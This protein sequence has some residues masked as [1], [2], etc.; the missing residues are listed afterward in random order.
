MLRNVVGMLLALAMMVALV[1]CQNNNEFAKYGG[2]PR[3]KTIEN[4]VSLSPNLTEVIGTISRRA[5]AGKTTEC[6]FPINMNDITNV[7]KGTEIDYELVAS[8]EPDLVIYDSDL[9]SE[10]DIEKL[11]ELGIETQGFAPKS[12]GEY[13][14]MMVA[15]AQYIASETRISDDLDDINRALE[16][17]SGAFP[18]GAV[19][20]T[21]LM[22]GGGT[23]Y[24]ASG[25]AT[26]LADIMQRSSIEYMGPDADRFVSINVEQLIAMNPDLIFAPTDSAEA[27]VADPRLATLRAVQNQQ[28]IGINPD[29]LLR[30]GARVDTLIGAIETQAQRAAVAKGVAN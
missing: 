20:A 5:L 14:E 3:P 8:V 16:T 25:N 27:I 2:Q 12:V 4:V 28:V 18:D 22:G 26:F 9:Y 15:I 10:S 21:V 19:S 13:E 17:A 24:M 30:V 29:I 23:E 1:G 7:V 6:N 11:R